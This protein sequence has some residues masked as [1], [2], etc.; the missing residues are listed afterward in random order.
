MVLTVK[1]DVVMSDDLITDYAAGNLSPAKHFMLACQSEISEQVCEKVAFQEDI[2]ATMIDDVKPVALSPLFIGEVLENLPKHTAN[3]HFGFNHT[4]LAPES[5][6]KSLGHG[7]RDIKWKTLVPGVAVHDI[8]G[9][10]RYEKGERVYLL[11]A[12]G[13]MRM[14]DHS[15]TGEEWSLIL[16]GSY[17][18]DDKTYRRGDIHIEH[19]NETHAPHIDEGED[20]IC[21]VMTQGPLVMKDFIPKVVQKVVGI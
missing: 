10:R 7:L 18:V 17:S 11:K 2:A 5:L 3:D 21:L 12:K 4:R 8:Y 16:T 15:H 19:D 9:N 20:C 6:R 13:G 14:P 1:D